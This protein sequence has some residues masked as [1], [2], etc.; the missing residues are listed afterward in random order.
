M[1]DQSGEGEWQPVLPSFEAWNMRIVGYVEQVY[2]P[3]VQSPKATAH[4]QL[5]EA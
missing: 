1:I 2:K 3:A 5:S 4:R